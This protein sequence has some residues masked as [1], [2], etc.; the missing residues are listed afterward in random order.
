MTS[1]DRATLDRI[2]CDY[3]GFAYRLAASH[4]ADPEAAR[5]LTQ[6]ILVAV[7]RAWPAFRQQCSE[8]TYVARIAHYRIAT[9]VG[10]AVR[11]PRRAELGDDIPSADL[12]PEEQLI[13]HD[14]RGR[15]FALVRTLPVAYREVALLLLEDFTPAEVADTL[16]ISANAVAIRGTRAREI[17]CCPASRCRRNPPP[18][19][20]RE[21]VPRP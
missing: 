12:S 9:H 17:R 7:W 14:E 4:E 2:L 1:A 13:R 18:M 5:D 16:G 8:R 11:Q 6:E 3:A 19:Q 21:P 10:R 20:K 15:L